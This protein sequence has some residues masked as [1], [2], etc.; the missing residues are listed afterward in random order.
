[1]RSS[2]FCPTPGSRSK[3]ARARRY[4]LALGLCLLLPLRPAIAQISGVFSVDSTNRPVE[5]V[6]V[7]VLQVFPGITPG[8]IL[9]VT[10]AADGGRT[11][12]GTALLDPAGFPRWSLQ[13]ASLLTQFPVEATDPASVLTANTGF[14]PNSPELA[15]VQYRSDVFADP[16]N[17][18][19]RS[20]VL[21]SGVIDA[22]SGLTQYGFQIASDTLQILPGPIGSFGQVVSLSGSESI[23][24]VN[25]SQQGAV[26]FDFAYTSP[27]FVQPISDPLSLTPLFPVVV[28][29][30]DGGFDM[31]LQVG[32]PG[33]GDFTNPVL[34]TSRCA[35]VRINADGSV[36]RSFELGIETISPTAGVCFPVQSS[37]GSLFF[38]LFEV[39]FDPVAFTAQYN[40][41]IVHVGADGIPV[42]ARTYLGAQL[43]VA[44]FPQPPT[45]VTDAAGVVTSVPTPDQVVLSG[46][47]VQSVLDPTTGIPMSG[48]IVARIDPATGDVLGQ[49]GLPFE[50]NPVFAMLLAFNADDMGFLAARAVATTPDPVPGE[51][52]P[53][54]QFA[55]DIVAIDPTLQTGAISR[56]DIETG[57]G[58]SAFSVQPDSLLLSEFEPTQGQIRALSFDRS[59]APLPPGCP[60]FTAVP[61]TS[62]TPSLTSQPLA[63]THTPI[64]VT[65][66]PAG[67]AVSAVE[68][69]SEPMS[70][71]VS[72]C[73]NALL[74]RPPEL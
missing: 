8:P 35:S 52:P 44:S 53:V 28:P 18:N 19:R 33:N 66:S 9:T 72:D 11:Y 22:V 21:R 41:H 3:R 64:D 12:T 13:P 50:R 20:T 27:A 45:E 63:V 7:G 39:I 51:P 62:M 16:T 67:T 2:R 4:P 30:T 24:L 71:L 29:L 49:Y 54:P 55:L 23:T 6:T 60:G 69:P 58:V 5:F 14:V 1:M 48:G 36:A 70:I 40:T 47:V 34:T 56:R 59:F 43:L 42:W 15:M 46:A 38:S 68:L 26:V 32:A 61:T 25:V 10:Y 65:V 73:N 37:D 74:P 17:P 57:W 31:H